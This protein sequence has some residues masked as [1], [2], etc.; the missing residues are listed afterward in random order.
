MRV[1]EVGLWFVAVRSKKQER[2]RNAYNMRQPVSNMKGQFAL[3]VHAY[4]LYSW[5]FTFYLIPKTEKLLSNSDIRLLLISQQ[6]HSLY[7]TR[8]WQ[9]SDL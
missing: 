1:V 6:L 5:D 9:Q 4:C 3:E 2:V 8:I 7:P